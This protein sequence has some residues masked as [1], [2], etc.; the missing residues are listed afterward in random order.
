MIPTPYSTTT[1]YQPLD[2]S[3][4]RTRQLCPTHGR[5]G[6]EAQPPTFSPA[7]GEGL[8]IAPTSS[9]FLF[10]NAKKLK[11]S[12]P[13][14]TR[15]LPIEVIHVRVASRRVASI[16]LRFNSP[17]TTGF[18]SSFDKPRHSINFDIQRSRDHSSRYSRSLGALNNSSVI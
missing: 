2:T 5:C 18:T 3:A 10:L 7:L 17:D 11:M 6:G 8:G 9:P 4:I 12:D 15:R 1:H 16:S 13:R 14:L